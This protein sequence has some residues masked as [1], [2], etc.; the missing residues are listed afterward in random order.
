MD[1]SQLQRG[2][3]TAP[4]RVAASGRRAPL[5]R[6]RVWWVAVLAVAIA[7]TGWALAGRRPA[8]AIVEWWSTHATGVL[9]GLLAALVALVA[10]A[11][12]V[13]AGR[14]PHSPA[15]P[16]DT[17][18]R[19]ADVV[20]A[21]STTREAIETLNLFLHHRTFREEMGGTARRGVL[22]EG[23]PGT[24][25]THLAKAMA[26]E[27]GVPFLF[28]SA[29]EFQSMFYGQTNRRVRAF[30]R[31]LRRAARAEGGAIGF[32]EEFDAIGTA[33][34]SVAVGHTRD[35]GSGIVNELLVQLQGFEQPTVGQRLH[36]R[37]IA[38]ANRAL[39]ARF[40][41]ANPVSQPANVL[42]V[43]TTNRAADL[44]PALLSPGRF[45]RIIHFDLPPR[46]DRIEI[47]EYYL[48]RKRHDHTVSAAFVADLTAGYTPARIERLL[49]EALVVALRDGQIAMTYRHVI[50]AQMVTEVGVAH[51]VGYH[52]EEKRR[53]ALHE[54][55][56]ALMAVLAGRDVKLASVLRRSGS[57]GM[58][59]H[60][61]VEERFLRTPSDMR[62]LM[63]IALAGRAAEIQELGEAS[64][65]VA[66][67][68]ATATELA[69]E[70]VGTL[71]AGS[72]LF[73]LQ[74]ARMEGADNLVTKVLRDER[75][76]ATADEL[77]HAAADRA[78]CTMLEHRR[79]LL[80]LADALCEADELSG[81]DVH[82]IVAGAM[83]H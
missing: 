72:S 8:V 67:D 70:L 40:R 6:R 55:G 23:A 64:G 76:R 31:A 35:G 52:P 38:V 68:L 5:R 75:A 26:A 36:A 1:I 48:A 29:S 61:E 39:P 46:A 14:S 51:D 17:G 77:L 12:F 57:L 16:H 59:A 63:T 60:G 43:A 4:S 25:K 41:R 80:A 19:L 79:A 81:D 24:G 3:A 32:I 18:V 2:S 83:I 45:D 69:A 73:S 66:D 13:Q 30:F 10:I 82:A 34:S 65:G 7:L 74:A 44:D 42:L 62:D 15:R 47:A 11:P 21:G 27:A 54:A 20:G 50:H 71:G 22:F 33:R 9:I 37:V 78:A 56:H 58:V 28:V 53:V 49:D